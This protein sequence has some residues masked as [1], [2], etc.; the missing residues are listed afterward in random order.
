M[1]NLSVFGFDEISEGLGL[2]FVVVKTI[3]MSIMAV[4]VVVSMR[5]FRWANIF[6]LQHVSALWAALNRTIFRHLYSFLLENSPIQYKK[7]SVETYSEPNCNVGISGIAS[8][9][10]ILLFTGRLDNDRVIE[11][12]YSISSA[13]AVSKSCGRI[14]YDLSRTFA[15]SV[16]RLH[17]EDINALHF[18]QDFQSLQT[19][20][21]LK[22]G[23]DSPYCRARTD[24]VCLALDLC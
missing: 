20:R 8:A 16:Q 21:L 1:S 2:G 5:I 9:T 18:P 23:G 3:V 12:A 10:S 6:H 19:R 4:A 14:S 17:I 13:I 11:R 7:L 15:R 22:I 24:E